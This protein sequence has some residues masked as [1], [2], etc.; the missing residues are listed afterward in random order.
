M[1][2]SKK[3]NIIF[4]D[5]DGTLVAEDSKVPDS[6]RRGT[7]AICRFDSTGWVLTIILLFF[8]F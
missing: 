6:A 2:G 5:V 1:S 8:I 4:L 3:A 7:P